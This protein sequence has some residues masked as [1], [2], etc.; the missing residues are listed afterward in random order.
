MPHYCLNL[1]YPDLIYVY[2]VIDTSLIYFWEA[3][4]LIIF[5]I[6]LLVFLSFNYQIER[7]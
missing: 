3:Y 7:V 6:S 1:Y 2:V 5:I 4:S